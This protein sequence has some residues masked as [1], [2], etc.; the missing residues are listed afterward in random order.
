MSFLVGAALFESSNMGPFARSLQ[1]IGL[2]LLANLEA[3][4][5]SHNQLE[6]WPAQ[7][8]GC[9][10]LRDLRLDHNQLHEAC[11][12]EPAK[13]GSGSCVLEFTLYVYRGYAF[14]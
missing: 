14:I 13:E 4:D 2:R 7:V 6:N 12:T 8:E 9:S 11:R 3:L 5:L 1:Q 10:T